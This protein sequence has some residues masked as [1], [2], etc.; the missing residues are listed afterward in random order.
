MA[1]PRGPRH[2]FFIKDLVWSG[3]PYLLTQSLGFSSAVSHFKGTLSSWFWKVAPSV[4][5]IERSRSLRVY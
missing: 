3:T 5:L 1:L 4:R 2:L